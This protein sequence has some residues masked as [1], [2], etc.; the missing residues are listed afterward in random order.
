ME[1][2]KDIFDEWKDERAARNWITR[3]VDSIF[4]WWNHDFKYM[5]LHLKYG[6]KNLIYWFHVIWNDRNYDSHYIFEVLKH[7][8]N[9]QSNYIGKRDIHTM[10]QRDSRRMMVCSKLI[11]L[12]QDDFYAS[13]YSNYHKTKH[14]FEPIEGSDSSTWKSRTLEENFSDYFNKYP[15]IYKRVLNGE[16]V[17]DRKDREEDQQIIAMNM[18][19]INQERAQTMLFN[20]INKNINGWWD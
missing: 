20:I 13:E 10:A 4:S 8:L 7:K 3:K 16:G 9:A 14:W 6:V 19:Y 5:H 17:F 15:L 18:S 2:D 1:P 11:Q 12:I